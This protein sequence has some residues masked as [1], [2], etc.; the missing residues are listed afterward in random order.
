MIE[1]IPAELELLKFH[2]PGLQ[3]RDDDHWLLIAGF[4]TCSE[5]WTQTAADVA[6]KFPDLPGQPPYGFWVRP[7]LSLKSGTGVQNYSYPVETPFGPGF[8]QFS[9]A[10]DEWRPA[11]DVRLGS[12]MLRWVESFKVRLAEGS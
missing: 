2:Y 7:G 3:Y 10:P 8:G 11:S 9:W 5:A 4:P 12:N 1:R 6:F